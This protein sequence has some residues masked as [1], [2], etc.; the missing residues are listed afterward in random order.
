MIDGGLSDSTVT[1]NDEELLEDMLLPVLTAGADTLILGC[2]HFPALIGTV[3]RI[4]H[5]YGIRH[6]IDSAKA[7]GDLLI[8]VSRKLK[9]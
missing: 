3:E 5:R 6:V 8:D 7:G 2:T 9:L 1:A 4:A